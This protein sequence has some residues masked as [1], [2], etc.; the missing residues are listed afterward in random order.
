M[1]HEKQFL[2]DE[3]LDKIHSSKGFLILRYAFSAHKAREFRDLLAKEKG[4]LE[5][6]RKR[7]FFKAVEKA[8]ITLHSNP[9]DG[10][11]GV[12]FFE[13]P[14]AVSKATI[15]YSEDNEKAIEVLAGHIEGASCSAEEVEALA[16]LPSLPEMRAQFL[17]LLEAPMAQTLAVFEAVM[18]SVP[19]CLE[20][21]AKLEQNT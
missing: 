2:L 8:G 17:G 12:I 6:V 5:V 18:T 15:K 7:V 19:Y 10:H 3:I 13:D 4:E 21:K 16:K 14:L 9:F 1:R 20:E 11:I